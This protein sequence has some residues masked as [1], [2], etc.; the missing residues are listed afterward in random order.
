MTADPQVTR[1]RRLDCCAVS[2]AMDRLKIRGQVTTLRQRSGSGRIAGRAVTVRL[3]TGDPPPGPPR[4]LGTTAIELAGPD[5]VIVVE[6]R[7]G[8]EAGCWGGLLTLGAKVRGVAGV[9]ADGPVR[10][11]D[12]AQG[13]DF[14]IFTNRTTC[15]TARGRVVEKET[16]GPVAIGELTVEP[17]DYVVADG[18]ACLFI[19]PADIDRVLDAAEEIVAREAAMA[20]AILAGTP[21]SEV[22]GGNYEHMLQQ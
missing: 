19:H 14:P 20:K 10:D 18:S 3:G 9:I 5:S 17:G 21:I 13:Y 7:T 15:L 12:E 1:L 2:D 8:V 16:N 6:Q 4:H 11:I 22:M